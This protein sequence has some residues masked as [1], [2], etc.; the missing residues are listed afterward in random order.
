M[1]AKGVAAC[2]QTQKPSTVLL[3]AKKKKKNR[4]RKKE[5]AISERTSTSFILMK[6]GL[7]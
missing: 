1:D 2:V 6:S 3:K 7:S 5:K 4:K